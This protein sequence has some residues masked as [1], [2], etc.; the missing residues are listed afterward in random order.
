[1]A[2]PWRSTTKSICTDTEK[3]ADATLHRHRSVLRTGRPTR[4]GAP[5]GQRFLTTSLLTKRLCKE[6]AVTVGQAIKASP[7]IRIEDPSS[8]V[9]ENGWSRLTTHLDKD[10]DLIDCL[11]FAI[12][13]AFEVREAFGFDRRFTQH[14][15]RLLPH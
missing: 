8:E 6:T 13:D 4:S 5:T 11:S 2:R 3:N 7:A 15:F 9:R 1:M 12:M 10:Y 14:G